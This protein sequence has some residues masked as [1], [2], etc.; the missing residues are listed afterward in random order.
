MTPA[1]SFYLLAAAR[2]EPLVLRRPPLPEGEPTRPSG[3]VIWIHL[4]SD[5]PAASATALA[6]RI[7][8][9]RPAAGFVVTCDEPGPTDDDLAWIARPADFPRAVGAFLTAWAPSA[10]IWVGGPV[11]PV[12]ASKARQAGIPMLLVNA[13]DALAS[14]HRGIPARDLLGLFDRIA[15]RGDLDRK[16][17][18]RAARRPV[19]AIG[20]LQRSPRP[21]DHDEGERLRL[22]AALQSRPVWFAA[23]A[24][25]EEAEAIREAHAIGQ[26]ASH[27]LLLIVQPADSGAAS[28]FLDMYRAHRSAGGVPPP[29]APALVADAP[30]EEGLW[31][32]LAS[33]SF[34]GG[35]LSGRSA[36]TDPFAAAALGSAI[37]HGPT[38]S[39][40]E[41]QFAALRAAG[42]TRPVRGAEGLGRAIEE[43]LAPDRTAELA[44]KAWAVVSDGAEATD[45]VA[46]EV[47]RLLDGLG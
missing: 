28:P 30:G 2:A 36:S 24:T 47:C 16:A 15:A 13:T 35:T 32:R 14:G 9:E 26:S 5:E 38:L 44:H 29:G 33:V 42:A 12:L 18:E 1:L 45:H 23:G 10:C 4:G 37:V 3:E 11:W 39:P 8:D 34:V 19:A 41:V 46:E 22:A 40:Y 20:R 6:M 17:L 7:A 21:R 25:A 31:Y 27:R 43:L